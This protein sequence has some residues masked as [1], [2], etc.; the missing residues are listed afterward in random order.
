[1]TELVNIGFEKDS[2]VEPPSVA[3]LPS[4]MN[5]S[6]SE[7]ILIKCSEKLPKIAIIY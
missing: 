7:G 4:E 1:M 5:E 2:L 3:A 6:E